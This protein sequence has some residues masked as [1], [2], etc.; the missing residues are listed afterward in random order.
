M[1]CVSTL[2]HLFSGLGVN[3]Q[4]QI[5][6]LMLLQIQSKNKKDILEL[7]TSVQMKLQ[8]CHKVNNNLKLPKMHELMSDLNLQ[9]ETSFFLF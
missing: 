2:F 3:L 5:Q 1:L 4:A 9:V 6:S 8:A 7:I